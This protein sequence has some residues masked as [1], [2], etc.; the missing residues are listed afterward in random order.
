MT[1]E[2]PVPS[3]TLTAP[4]AVPAAGPTGA[5]VSRREL[6]VH[7]RKNAVGPPLDVSQRMIRPNAIFHFKHMKQRQLIVRFAPLPVR[8]TESLAQ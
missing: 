2:P 4:V 1:H 6:R 7:P 5:T 3:L 8:D